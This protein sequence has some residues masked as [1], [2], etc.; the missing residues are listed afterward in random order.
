MMM[1]TCWY[2]F[3]VEIVTT[4]RDRLLCRLQTH[5]AVPQAQGSVQCPTQNCLSLTAF[6]VAIVV[7]LLLMLGY[8]M[9]R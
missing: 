9:Y 2:G 3:G 4:K 8:S 1:I 6:L 5:G 7:Q